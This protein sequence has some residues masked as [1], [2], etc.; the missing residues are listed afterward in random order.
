MSCPFK[1]KY[2]LVRWLVKYKGFTKSAANKLTKKQCLAIWYKHG[3][4]IN[5]GY[6]TKQRGGV[7]VA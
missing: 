5:G 3:R 6:H 1:Y 2:E 7:L 4:I